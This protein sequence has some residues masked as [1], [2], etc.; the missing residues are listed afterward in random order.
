MIHYNKVVYRWL[1]VG[2]VFILIQTVIG[3]ITRLTGSGL[4]ITK[5]E[6]VTGTFPPMTAQA[7]AEAFELYSASPQY[8]MINQG[9]ELSQFKFIYFWEY[10]HRLWA[11]LLGFVFVIPFFLFLKKKWLSKYLI[12]RLIVTVFMVGVVASFGWIMVASGLIQRPWVNAYKLSFHLI[13]ALVVLTFHIWTT[14]RYRFGELSEIREGQKFF[15]GVLLV[16]A[17]LVWMQVFLGGIV[18]GMHAALAYPS[19]PTYNGEWIPEP[20]MHTENYK[21]SNMMDYD[22][23]GFAAAIVQFF[24]RNMAYVITLVVIIISVWYR[25]WLWSWNGYLGRAWCIWT[26][27]L[28]CQILLGVLTL[29]NSKSSIP[30]L[31]GVLHQFVGILFLSGIVVILYFAR[32]PLLD[33]N[34]YQAK[35]VDDRLS[36]SR[37]RSV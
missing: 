35:L 11:R 30:V 33:G 4:S 20:L 1:L 19:F 8:D 26:I 31:Y 16:L 17:A 24:H 9:M 23:S 21:I 25:K 37:K 2:I 12:S 32:R 18:S 5:W 7:W 29:L 6:I 3:G 27:L 15:Y 13:L 14:V 36:S 22:Q 28:G 10:F 34:S